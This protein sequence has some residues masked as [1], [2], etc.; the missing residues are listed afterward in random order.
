[1]VKDAELD[2]HQVIEMWTAVFDKKIEV[3]Q[4]LL[5]ARFNVWLG[6][7]EEDAEGLRQNHWRVCLPLEINGQDRH[8]A[9]YCCPEAENHRVS[10]VNCLR[11][12]VLGNSQP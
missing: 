10:I 4:L 3:Q 5:F 11:S 8:Q 9:E 2:G 6:R 1:M 7:A 12:G